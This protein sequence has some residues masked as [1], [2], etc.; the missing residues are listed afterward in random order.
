MGR[1]DSQQCSFGSLFRW[2]VVF[3]CLFDPTKTTGRR[4]SLAYNVPMN[5]NR[6]ACSLQRSLFGSEESVE[7]CEATAVLRRVDGLGVRG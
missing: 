1:K 2:T 5:D 3:C 4:L 7:P 6:P